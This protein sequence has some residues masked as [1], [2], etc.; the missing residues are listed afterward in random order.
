MK[1]VSLSATALIS[2]LVVIWPNGS[3]FAQNVRNQVV[4]LN[5]ETDIVSSG[6]PNTVIASSSSAGAPVV[7]L[8]TD[9]AQA[10]TD[11]LNAG[12]KPIAIQASDT[13]LRTTYVLSKK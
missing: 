6:H 1:T 11:V 13:S 8:G 5:C 4:I 2:I 7:N 12:F 9:C 3:V 10:L